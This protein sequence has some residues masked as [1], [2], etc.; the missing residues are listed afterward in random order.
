M[1]IIKE[2][3]FNETGKTVQPAVFSVFPDEWLAGPAKFDD[4]AYSG[5]NGRDAEKTALPPQP[6]IDLAAVQSLVVKSR[7]HFRAGFDEVFPNE[8]IVE[9][10]VPGLTTVVLSRVP[11]RHVPRPIWPLDPDVAWS[12]A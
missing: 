7:G 10:D 8:R 1:R 3:Y 11:W 4:G 5:G 6:V 12:G 9:V 2:E